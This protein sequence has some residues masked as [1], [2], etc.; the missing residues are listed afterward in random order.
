M[1]TRVN[2]HPLGDSAQWNGPQ[3]VDRTP[4]TPEELQAIR[5]NAAAKRQQDARRPKN[6]AYVLGLQQNAVEYIQR[7]EARIAALE[8]AN[9]GPDTQLLDRR[10]AE[11]EQKVN[12]SAPR[13]ERVERRA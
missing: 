7:L 4:L 1:A 13:G 12:N 6:L 10:L 2:F 11:L 8:A 9:N 3:P 5:D